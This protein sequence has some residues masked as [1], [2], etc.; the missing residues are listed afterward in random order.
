MTKREASLLSVV[1]A[2]VP[3]R[4]ILRNIYV[5]FFS[6]RINWLERTLSGNSRAVV[7]EKIDPFFVKMLFRFIP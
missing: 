5:Q 7:Q 4:I 6:L 3:L 2:L 1:R